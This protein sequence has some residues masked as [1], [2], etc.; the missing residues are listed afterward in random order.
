MEIIA[1]RINTIHQLQNLKTN[2]GAEVDIR[3][4]NNEFS[5]EIMVSTSMD[6]MAY[7]FSYHLCFIFN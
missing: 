4:N 5:S 2:L 1:H 3:S 7:L 6:K